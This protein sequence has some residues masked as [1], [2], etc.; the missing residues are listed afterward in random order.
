MAGHPLRIHPFNFW[1]LWAPGTGRFPTCGLPS[2]FDHTTSRRDCVLQYQPDP[3]RQVFQGSCLSKLLLRQCAA[4][5]AKIPIIQRLGCSW[6]SW[7][8]CEKG[9]YCSEPRWNFQELKI[10]SAYFCRARGGFALD[11]SFIRPGWSFSSNILTSFF[12]LH[13]QVKCLASWTFLFR[14]TRMGHFERNSLLFGVWKKKL[15]WKQPSRCEQLHIGA[16][17]KF[18]WKNVLLK[19]AQPALSITSFHYYP[20][21]IAP[22]YHCSQECHVTE[23]EITK[24][25]K[26]LTFQR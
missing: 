19:C 11:G 7:R 3:G 26:W 21:K 23:D 25:T 16:S 2:P 18:E 15:R 20:I 14:N 13:F 10:Q 17:R 8:G 24:P 5:S 1:L 6:S 9:S 12:S 22:T 4:C